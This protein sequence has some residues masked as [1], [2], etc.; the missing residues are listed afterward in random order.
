[1]IKSIYI[2]NPT[3]RLTYIPKP[4]SKF[5]FYIAFYAV[6][7]HQMFE[8]WKGQLNYC[9]ISDMVNYL[10]YTNMLVTFKSTWHGCW[11]APNPKIK[12][13]DTTILIYDLY[14]IN[15]EIK[16]IFA[17]ENLSLFWFEV[18]DSF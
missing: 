6:E 2:H 8:G 18:Y 9:S 16:P 12:I 14:G 5:F 3:A 13:G 17:L 11:F 1:M 7:T 15:L 4:L 10:S